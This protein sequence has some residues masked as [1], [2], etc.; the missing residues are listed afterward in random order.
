M[1]KES[2]SAGV[3]GGAVP[4]GEPAKPAK[5][6]AD[7]VVQDKV[8]KTMRK[9]EGRVS[10]RQILTL[11]E[12]EKS[13]KEQRAE[14]EAQVR[15]GA[16]VEDGPYYAQLDK[17]EEK[18]RPSKTFLTEQLGKDK[19]EAVWGNLEMKPYER[20]KYGLKKEEVEKNKAVLGAIEQSGKEGKP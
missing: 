3:F 20:L 6:A 1:T 13:V 7:P 8:E 18:G 11:L 9:L 16:T 14:L 5:P 19:A 4:P 2:A 12:L 10:Q 15:E 17:G